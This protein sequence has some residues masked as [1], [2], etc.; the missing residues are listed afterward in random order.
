MREI[1]FRCF[2]E[3]EIGDFMIPSENS[4]CFMVSNGVGFIVYDEHK[5]IIDKHVHVMQFTGLTDK[6]GVEIYEGDILDTGLGRKKV[7]EYFK[8]GFWLNANSEGAEWTLRQHNNS[9]EII[10]NIHEN[11]PNNLTGNQ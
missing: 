4:D 3:N 8:D 9:S 1:K 5:N 10:G 6:N 2:I 7:V 11:N